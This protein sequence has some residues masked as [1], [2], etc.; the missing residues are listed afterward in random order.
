MPCMGPSKFVY[1]HIKILTFRSNID[2]YATV[3]KRKFSK[4]LSLELKKL[5]IKVYYQDGMFASIYSRY[6]S[7]DCKVRQ[8]LN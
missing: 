1:R 2:T 7:Y 8:A 4:C 5:K 6:M 3:L